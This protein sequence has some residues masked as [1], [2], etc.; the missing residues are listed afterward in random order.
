MGESTETIDFFHKFV[1]LSFGTQAAPQAHR[2]IIHYTE[3]NRFGRVA[4][5]LHN[6]ESISLQQRTDA[7][8]WA[9]CIEALI[10]TQSGTI[11]DV[12]N[13]KN[14]TLLLMIFFWEGGGCFKFDFKYNKRQVHVVSPRSWNTKR[15]FH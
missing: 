1:S 3:F 7:R 10:P 2:S 12:K 14:I 15:D 11:F 9:V 13:K 6:T 8:V 4:Q 5:Y